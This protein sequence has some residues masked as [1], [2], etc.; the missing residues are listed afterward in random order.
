MVTIV[1]CYNGNSYIHRKRE[2]QRE[3]ERERETTELE[4]NTLPA[5]TTN[6]LYWPL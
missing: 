4:G 2:R 5:S 1:V 6:A 3:R